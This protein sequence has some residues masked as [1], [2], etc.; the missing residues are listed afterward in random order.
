[1]GRVS[2]IYNELLLYLKQIDQSS[3]QTRYDIYL[4]SFHSKKSKINRISSHFYWPNMVIFALYWLLW[5]L[6]LFKDITKNHLTDRTILYI[7]RL[8]MLP[9]WNYLNTNGT[10]GSYKITIMVCV[11]KYQAKAMIKY[12]YIKYEYIKCITFYIN[13]C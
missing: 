7:C 6:K 4:A 2:V 13:N 9:F 1:M 3:K 5:T 11:Y 8:I 10:K 12:E